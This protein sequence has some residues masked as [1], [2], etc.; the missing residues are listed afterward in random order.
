MI[1]RRPARRIL[2]GVVTTVVMT[3]VVMMMVA[4]ASS[5]AREKAAP[6]ATEKQLEFGALRVQVAVPTGWEVL[7]HPRCARRVRRRSESRRRQAS[8]DRRP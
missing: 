8:R 4:A 1:A 3:T 5:C 7:D 2:A 6:A